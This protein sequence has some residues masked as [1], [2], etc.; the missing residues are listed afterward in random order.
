MDMEMDVDVDLETDVGTYIADTE[1]D[2]DTETRDMDIHD[3][4]VVMH[5]TST[6]YFNVSW[7]HYLCCPV[8]PP[9]LRNSLK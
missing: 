1:I 6:K 2:L 5:C 8:F 9:E 3:Q 4:D 7:I